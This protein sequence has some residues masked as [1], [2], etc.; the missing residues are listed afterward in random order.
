ML[1]TIILAKFYLT[2]NTVSL[3]N[4]EWMR[5]LHLTGVLSPL[6]LRSADDG[7]KDRELF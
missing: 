5:F 3:V 2:F 6:F 4:L 7:N 1:N